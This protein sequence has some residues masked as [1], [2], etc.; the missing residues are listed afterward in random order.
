MKKILLIA[1]VFFAYKAFA[2]PSLAAM[3]LKIDQQETL[4]PTGSQVTLIN[5]TQ[6]SILFKNNAQL[7]QADA[8]QWLTGNLSLRQNIDF[9]QDE[10]RD[11]TTGDFTI[12][13]IHQYYKGI[14][15]EHGVIASTSKNG[16]LALMQME[17]YSVPD[18]FNTRPVL[19]EQE[20]LAKAVA[21]V[22][23]S[24]YV[25]TGYT[26]KDPDYLPPHAELVIVQT[27]KQEGEVCLA[28]KFNI[29]AL[30]PMSRAY[31]Y[32]NA[33]DGTVVL[34]DAIIKHARDRR[35]EQNT[36]ANN[37]IQ[38]S[39]LPVNDNDAGKKGWRITANS[40]G[41]AA[42]RY[43]GSRSIVT[44][45][46]TGAGAKPYRLRQSRNGHSIITLDYQRQPSN[47]VTDYDAQSIDFTDNDNKW[48]AAEF[49][50]TN[51]DDVALDAHY[52]MQWVSDYWL[53]IHQRNGWDD[54]N[55]S[56]YGYV[57][58][59]ENRYDQN[60]SFISF[61]R[62]FDN[63]FWNGKNMHF[64]DGNGTNDPPSTSLDDCAHELGHAITATTSNLVYKWEAGAMNE[65]F[66]DI[67]AACVSN[68][69]ITQDP[70][71]TGE[72]VWRLFEKSTNPGGGA[73]AGARDMQ[74]PLKFNQP[75][76]YNSTNWVPGNYSVCPVES[77]GGNDHC[78]VHKNSGVLNKWFF[79][80]TQGEISFNTKFQPYAVTGL[81]FAKSEEI[82]YLMEANL[83]PNASYATAMTVSLNIA[84]AKYGYGSAEFQTVKNAW[85]AVGVD[86]NIYNM[87]N[88][89]VFTTNN[90][91]SI[92]VGKD[93]Y[94]WAGTN[95][96]GLYR[97]NGTAWAK[98]TEL[99]DVRINDIKPDKQGGIWIAQS[100][101]SGQIGGG[102]SIAGGVNYYP[103]STSAT[104]LFYSVDPLP[105]IPSRN[106]RCMYI[107]TFLTNDGA[108][109]KAWVATLAYIT[110]SSSASGMLGQGLYS[111]YHEFVP[112]NQGINIASGTAGCLTVGGIKSEIWTFVQA[113]NGINQLLTYD[114]LSRILITTYDHNSVPLIPSG[115]LARA[116][117]GDRKN[118]IWVGLATGGV[119]VLDEH[120]KWHNI[121]FP[122]VFP[123]GIAVNY[124]AI[125]G[126]K[127]GD[128]YIGTTAGLVLFDHG[129]GQTDRIDSLQFYKLY[130]TDNGLPSVNINAMA[131]DTSRFKLIVATDSGII[132]WEPPCLGNSCE[133][134]RSNRNA[135]S[136]SKGPG[137]WSNPATWNTGLIPDSTTN[138][139]ITDTITVD[140]NAQ[141]Q[142][143]SVIQPGMVKL[144][145]GVKLTIFETA[146]PIMT[147][148]P[149]AIKRRRP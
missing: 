44:D 53:N 146:P 82:A 76:T 73:N 136:E 101:K 141:C 130:T 125:T 137:N 70:S 37:D 19:S 108:N 118:R 46:V 59:A 65:G 109:P 116:I 71:L 80:I 87:S 72:L 79:L 77:D 43:S 120:R 92:G 27:Y 81:G 85:F 33:W 51:L 47:T 91:T 67:W 3:K 128:V 63:A 98:M 138:V 88:T 93:G 142:S 55:S 20:A 64:G 58:A 83:T 84:T 41:T 147:D 49:H 13:K 48:T 26:G 74:N 104:S 69:A 102:S 11:I 148:K 110:S 89:P 29:Y 119:L 95:Y 134:R 54:K 126:N 10:N 132:F 50:N 96:S 61:N 124:N 2:Q 117:Y 127:Y 15:V 24:L 111:T 129:I 139:L 38:Q 78:G 135:Y 103:A 86:S 28:Y 114:P 17:Y 100:G 149:T 90:F 5:S 106:A 21:F 7:R 57:H 45:F 34:D 8:E 97:Y 75:S 12:K 144:N 122:T 36:K 131:Y 143:V 14:K 42:T 40:I 112:V 94:V 30:E 68:Y 6:A 62:W 60:G 66:S 35:D 4:Q 1:S 99:T 105:H 133:I 31:I 140:I 123:P 145:T 107:D 9:F 18:K 115:F 121:N 25:W 23:A 113:N 22:G 39:N 52:N 16:A 32:V 56:F